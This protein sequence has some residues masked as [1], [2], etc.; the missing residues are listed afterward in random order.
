MKKTIL[1]VLL[2]LGLSGC[3]KDFY[4]QRSPFRYKRSTSCPANDPINWW[5]RNGT[6]NKFKAGKR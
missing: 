4:T 6:G 5:Y 1:L 2:G 3:Y